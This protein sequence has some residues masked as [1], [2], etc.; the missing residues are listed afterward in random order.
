MDRK[1]TG[2]IEVVPAAVQEVTVVARDLGFEVFDSDNHMYETEDAFTRHLPAEHRGAIT[3][4]QV[5]GR[6]KIAIK[7]QISEYIPNPTF[8]V[9]APPGAQEEYYRHGNPDGKS[10]REIFGKPIR[11]PEWARNA[12]ARLPHL[13]ELGVQG[14][15]MFPTLASLLEERMRDDP[16]LTH[17]V[18]HSLNQWIHDEWTFNYH[19]RIFATPIVTLP[20]VEKAIEELEWCLERGAR[21][22]LIRPAPAWGLRGPR[23]PGLPEFD[24]FW[25]RVQ[26]AGVLVGMHSSDSGYADLVSI[27]EGRTEFLPFKPNP[28]RL[29]VMQNRA[30][31]D[32]M[33]AMV[34][35]GALTRFPHLR[36]ATIEN[37]GTWV[38]P[39]VEKF[40]GIYKKMP[41]EFAEHPVEAF[42]R[43]VYV[44]PFWEDALDGL[45]DIMSPDRLLFGSDY[46]H[47]EGLGN[48][49]S[50][51][52][53]LPSSLSQ[54]DAA[55]IM[56][57]NLKELLAV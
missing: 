8:E 32:M 38:A 44:N 50:F 12:Q 37:G 11:C 39:L 13:D 2:R 55:K 3:Y 45:I 41:Q 48:P 26:E 46:P 6:T 9:V 34:C 20:I 43:N 19:D 23:S 25:A 47:P 29:L 7:G 36:I 31:S 54:A 27:W 52:D 4:V 21:C 42:R 40:E 49:I 16:D 51:Y 57:G 18:V 30:I 22:I 53:D 17:A 33:T 10:L 5:N 14:S 24:P 56:G 35:H 1:S 28:L 15:L